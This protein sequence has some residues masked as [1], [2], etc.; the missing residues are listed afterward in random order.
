MSTT[1]HTLPKG[2][3][4]A[5]D[6][7]SV[8]CPTC[9]QDKPLTPENWYRAK[10]HGEHALYTNSCKQCQQTYRAANRSDDSRVIRPRGSR[11]V[12]EEIIEVGDRTYTRV[13]KPL[14]PK[15][16]RPKV[17]DLQQEVET[18]D[19]LLAELQ[20]KVAELEAATKSRTRKAR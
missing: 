9:G 12:T 1:D 2:V 3:A 5:D 13:I 10:K 7:V 8:T 18:K 4:L 19:A 17:A 14:A 11:K 6:D 15:P 16:K 20:R